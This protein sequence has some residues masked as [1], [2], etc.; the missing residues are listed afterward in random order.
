MN[1]RVAPASRLETLDGVFETRSVFVVDVF[2][3][4]VP[5]QPGECELPCSC[6]AELLNCGGGS[7]LDWYRVC[8][9]MIRED[10]EIA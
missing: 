2:N 6:T 5:I 4:Q 3:F 1:S 7:D 9:R 10:R 8:Q